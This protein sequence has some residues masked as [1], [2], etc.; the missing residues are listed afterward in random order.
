M[1]IEIER[2]F[3][4]VGDTWKHVAATHYCQG[5]LNRDKQRTVRIRIA[6]ADGFITIK[7][8]TTGLTR[9]EYEY[10]LPIEDARAL[11]ELC[12]GPVIEKYRRVLDL[13]GTTWEVDEFI[14]L[15]QGLV[16]AEV[17]LTHEDEPF[18]K[19][20]WLGKEVTGDTRYYNSSLSKLPFTQWPQA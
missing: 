2:K 20:E 10:P 5:Y 15:N 18:Y 14:G 19:P 11:L 3:L 6:G 17:E 7:G 1:A 9:M 13:E 12:E 16:V 4:V 8:K